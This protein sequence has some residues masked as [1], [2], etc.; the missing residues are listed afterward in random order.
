VAFDV[1]DADFELFALV[2]FVLLELGEFSVE[3][4]NFRGEDGFDAVDLVSS[5]GTVLMLRPLWL[6]RDS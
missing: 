1:R 5:S 4:V 3:A 6:D 2:D